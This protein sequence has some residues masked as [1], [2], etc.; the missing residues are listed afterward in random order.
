VCAYQ[1]NSIKSQACYGSMWKMES[2]NQNFSDISSSSSNSI[3]NHGSAVVET[4]VSSVATRE[5]QP[6]Q[7]QHDYVLT[8]TLIP[9]QFVVD[10]K[11]FIERPFYL[12]TVDWPT[13]KVRGDLLQCDYPLMPGDVLR[14]NPSLLSA[15]KIASLYRCD[16]ELIISVAG[17]ITHSG[18]VIAGVIPPL[19][20]TLDSS[21]SQVGLINTILTGPHVRLFANEA[22]STT[23]KVPWYCNTDMAT[24]DMELPSNSYTPSMDITP[25]NGNYGTLVFLVLN[26]L[27]PSAG[28]STSLKI[29]VE[30]VFNSLDMR[31]PTP[32]YV[33]WVSQ[34]SFLATMGTALAD[35]LTTKAK[36]VTADFI[37]KARS[38]FRKETGLHNPNSSIINQ[39]VIVSER[40]FLNTIDTQTYFETL[41]TNLGANRIVDC[42]VFNT[43]EDEML[44]S[45]II[46]KK[47]YLGTFRVNQNDPT[48]TLLWVRPISPNQ[49]AFD[50]SQV[51]VKFTNNIRLLHALSRAWRGDIKITIEAVMNNKQQVKL[52]LL[53]M[54]N[55]SVQ[56]LLAYPDYRSI[57]NAPSH[58]MEFSEGGQT[59]EVV[60]PYLCRNELTQC[61]AEQYAE[62]LFHG[63]YYIYVA[64]PLA[65]SGDSP[66]DVY[67]NVYYQG[68]PN[69]QFF[70]YSTQALKVSFPGVVKSTKFVSQS[71][72][73]MNEP[74][75]QEDQEQERQP[76]AAVSRLQ[77]IDSIRDIIRRT[78]NVTKFSR[79]LDPGYNYLVYDIDEI[80]GET[81]AMFTSQYANPMQVVA[82]MYYG[83]FPSTRFQ[84]RV[85]SFKNDDNARTDTVVS[86]VFYVPQKQ[87]VFA[88]QGLT[89]GTVVKEALCPLIVGDQNIDFPIPYQNLP[90]TWNPTLFAHE[91]HVPNTSILKFVGGPKKNSTTYVDP[92]HKLATQDCGQLVFVMYN[93]YSS[94]FPVE[95]L[96][97]AGAS[98]E[99]RF[100]FHAVAP[101]VEY[102]T[103]G[104]EVVTDG[105]G[106]VD[107][108]DALPAPTALSFVNFT[109]T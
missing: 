49:Y 109:R 32:R 69:L 80:Y 92:D 47:Q 67:F 89:Y 24:L 62:A 97:N 100:G 5:I 81:T 27:A 11:P 21:F 38:I 34:S 63:L 101:L 9:N 95:I 104:S 90:I 36:T 48:G 2:T 91:F 70:G 40:N 50:N 46:A 18:C 77:T 35:N 16:L 102:P 13:G 93:P 31:V 22:T 3:I 37:D 83:K 71:M 65:N 43:T 51:S 23:L 107:N 78:Y 94:P 1:V 88:A 4:A 58:L 73:V 53:Q 74:Q 14:S 59:H 103:V 52:R 75:K 10:A 15:T 28:S 6:P 85:V 29:T 8:D 30:A 56:C 106:R 66:V 60:L 64:Q 19:Y 72:R 25:V 61:S 87:F 108:L 55:P 98:D 17:T 79:E 54:Y 20:G 57:L 105:M 68:M 44:Y 42:P 99:C 41:D 33:N 26:A 12:T 7:N 76:K 84:V 45:H 39:R 82:S 86:S 96:V